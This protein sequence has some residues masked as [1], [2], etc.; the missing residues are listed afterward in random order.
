MKK[1]SEA[2]IINIAEATIAKIR[3]SPENPYKNLL[4]VE[5]ILKEA[6]PAHIK[7]VKGILKEQFKGQLT[8]NLFKGNSP[9]KPQ[10]LYNYLYEHNLL[11][12]YNELADY[13]NFPPA[14]ELSK[15]KV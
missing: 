6:S 13:M 15:K 14:H 4:F 1:L 8:E 11:S 7:D 2:E 5:Q 3:K 12:K 9:S 10:H